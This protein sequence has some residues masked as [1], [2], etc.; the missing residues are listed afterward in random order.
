MVLIQVFIRSD[1]RSD[2][3]RLIRLGE[4]LVY[5]IRTTLKSRHVQGPNYNINL[6]GVCSYILP[7]K[8]LFKLKFIN[9]KRNLSCK[10]WIY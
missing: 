5:F 1:L 2:N 10:T 3:G 9:L 4:A 7:D 6:G 8:F